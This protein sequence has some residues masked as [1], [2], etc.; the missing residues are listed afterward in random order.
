[1]REAKDNAQSVVVI[2]CVEILIYHH[3]SPPL[4][5]LQ[6]DQKL[7][8]RV[9]L[10]RAVQE[11]MAAVP[12]LVCTSVR[13]WLFRRKWGPWYAASQRDSFQRACLCRGLCV[14]GCVALIASFSH[15]KVCMSIC[16]FIWFRRWVNDFIRWSL[17]VSLRKY[18][19]W[20]VNFQNITKH[21]QL[22]LQIDQQYDVFEVYFYITCRLA[23]SFIQGNY[24]CIFNPWFDILPGEQLEVWCLARR[25]YDMGQG[26]NLFYWWTS[27]VHCERCSPQRCPSSFTR[28]AS[29]AQ[30]PLPVVQ[31]LSNQP[32]QKLT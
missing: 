8:R 5:R 17:S 15:S 32:F 24:H 13:R 2:T 10:S 11:K 3:A 26:S 7:Q 18:A 31:L 6:P 16:V 20:H 21:F 27:L 23:D 14:S 29:M 1:M 22:F 9:L 12:G 25:H 28:L 19:L 4:Q 30:T